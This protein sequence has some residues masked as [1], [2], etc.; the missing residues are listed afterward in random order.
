M[1]VAESADQRLICGNVT[2]SL[3]LVIV[4][5]LYPAREAADI[6]FSVIEAA[7]SPAVIVAAG[8]A[9]NPLAF[10]FTTNVSVADGALDDDD[11]CPEPAVYDTWST[12]VVGDVSRL[13]GKVTL[14]A[15]GLP[16]VIAVGVRLVILLPLASKTYTFGR[17]PS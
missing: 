16:S 2:L 15:V 6:P 7:E 17:M 13:L 8:T 9:V 5:V 1:L 4:N 12:Y 14:R 3:F 11:V 10:D